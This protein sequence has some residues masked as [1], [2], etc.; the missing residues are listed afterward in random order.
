MEFGLVLRWKIKKL[1]RL[2]VNDWKSLTLFISYLRSAYCILRINHV[3]TK[4]IMDD[5]NA[6]W[7][8]L[9]D[10]VTFL[11][12]HLEDTFDYKCVYAQRFRI[13]WR[14]VQLWWSFSWWYDWMDQLRCSLSIQWT[15]LQMILNARLTLSPYNIL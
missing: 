13:W 8:T 15:S 5:I 9:R 7:T 12:T 10:F 14:A 3:H 6:I 2:F 4:T 11:K 1:I